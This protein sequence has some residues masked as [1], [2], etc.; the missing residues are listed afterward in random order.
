VTQDC[1]LPTKQLKP[2]PCINL[3]IRTMMNIDNYASNTVL[4]DG[5]EPALF[6]I[7]CWR[8]ADLYLI[9]QIFFKGLDFA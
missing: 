6:C 8:T 1:L 4:L 3:D 2:Q 7:A 5:C 9:R